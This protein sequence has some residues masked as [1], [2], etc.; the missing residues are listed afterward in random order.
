MSALK[1]AW[2]TAEKVSRVI[3]EAVRWLVILSAALI[4]VRIIL[5]WRA[6]TDG[7]QR[8]RAGDPEA[9]GEALGN[10]L[11]IGLAFWLFRHWQ[12]K[13]AAGREKDH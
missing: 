4:P 7:I 9:Q 10:V 12:R 8:F 5:N 11:I 13:R 6:F 2:A 3:L 1:N